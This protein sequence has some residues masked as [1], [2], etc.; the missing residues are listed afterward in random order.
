MKTLFSGIALG[1]VTAVVGAQTAIMSYSGCENC[2]VEGF[3][4]DSTGIYLIHNDD[5]CSSLH[6]HASPHPV[7]GGEAGHNSDCYQ[8]CISGTWDDYTYLHHL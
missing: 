5:A 8:I 2:D 7:H 4:P 6:Y 3:T 1:A